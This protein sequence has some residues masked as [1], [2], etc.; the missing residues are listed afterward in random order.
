MAGGSVT[1]TQ[2]GARAPDA[3]AGRSIHQRRWIAFWLFVGF[4][5]AYIAVTRGHFISTDEIIVYQATASLWQ[6]GDLSIETTD[7]N[8]RVA[9]RNGRFYGIVNAGQSIASVPLYG[10]GRFLGKVLGDRA[11]GRWLAGPLIERTPQVRWGGEIEIFFVNLFNAFVTALLCAVFFLFS[12]R[13]GARARTSLAATLLL[14]FTTYV[15]GSSS[16]YFQHGA[17]TLLIFAAFYFLFVD[18]QVPRARTRL[19]AALM[20]VLM[21]QFRFASALAIPALLG[22]HFLTVWRRTRPSAARA[23][24]ESMPLIAG[25]GLA[26]AAHAAVQYLKFG[27]IGFVGNYATVSFDA[28][29]TQSL[30]GFLLSPG[31]SIFLFTPLLVLVPWTFREFNRRFTALSL[32]L[33]AQL[34]I[35]L[36]AFGMNHNW[37]GMWCFGPRYLTLLV[38]LLMLPLALWL[39]DRGRR[40]WIVTSMLGLAGL[41]MQLIDVAVNYWLVALHERYLDARPEFSFLFS[42]R[43]SP[44][45]AH[46]RALLAGDG[47]VDMWLVNVWRIGGAAPALAFAV[48]LV[49]VAGLAGWKALQA[50]NVVDE[51]GPQPVAAAP[52]FRL[53]YLA[54]CGVI[55]VALTLTGA[56]IDHLIPLIALT[57]DRLM[58]DGVETLYVRKDPVVAE[59]YFAMILARNAAHY[60]ANFQLARALDAQERG[61]EAVPQWNRVLLLSKMNKDPKTAAIAEER[62]AREP[63]LDDQ[64]LMSLAI[65]VRYD[66]PDPKRSV[67]MFRE[68]VRRNP[69]NADMTYELASALDAS[70]DRVQARSIWEREMLLA[71]AARDEAMVTLVRKRLEQVDR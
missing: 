17:E 12:M 64:T 54:A 3:E 18:S 32:F 70:G 14:G 55:V 33:F 52:S 28:P 53:R 13:T 59:H 69:D 10:A 71:S 38:P 66:V 39:Q 19:A 21:V 1:P 16:G 5:A 46:S 37:H 29:L 36:I 68:L 34:A 42:V 7:V 65:H 35:T 62:L 24:A 4:S 51:V 2:A 57:D 45:L 22:Y 44:I 25:T 49:C 11:V 9:G 63:H 30:R 48:P 47:R 58:H 43:D 23:F 50:A 26:F 67:A 27:T 60:G 61:A 31:D 56:A 6:R 15:G 8:T 20:I 40:A 41:W